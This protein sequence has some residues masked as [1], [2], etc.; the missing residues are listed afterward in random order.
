MNVSMEI[1]NKLMIKV[2]AVYKAK[3]NEQRAKI[4]DRNQPVK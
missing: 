2:F 3:V 1:L 4:N